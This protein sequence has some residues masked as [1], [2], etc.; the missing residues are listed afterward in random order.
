MA[1]F[2]PETIDVVAALTVRDGRLL[3]AQRPPGKHLGGLWEFPGGKIEPGESP[4]Q[5]LIRELLEELDFTFE[6]SRLVHTVTHDY[7]D[8]SIRLRF[9][10]G[11]VVAGEPRAMEQNNVAWVM[12]RG[13]HQYQFPPADAQLIDWLSGM[14]DFD[15]LIR[16]DRD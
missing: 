5:A 7:P 3:I 12:P 1:T 14:E 16:Q 9:F 2:K 8:R 15:E 4:E 6:P 10:S 11:T 13:L